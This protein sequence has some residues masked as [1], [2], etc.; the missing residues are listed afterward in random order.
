MDEFKLPKD[1]VTKVNW[2]EV[3]LFDVRVKKY[4][5][6]CEVEKHKLIWGNDSYLDKQIDEQR[7][8][9]RKKYNLS[10]DAKDPQ[11]DISDD[12]W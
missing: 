1:S 3:G 4:E 11:F 2:A 5:R 12:D 10:V 6:Q 7:A 8:K 9:R